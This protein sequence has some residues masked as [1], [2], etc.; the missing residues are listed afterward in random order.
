MEEWSESH[1]ILSLPPAAVGVVVGVAEDE[2]ELG[3]VDDEDDD[4]EQ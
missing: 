1:A 2:A 3:K 4:E